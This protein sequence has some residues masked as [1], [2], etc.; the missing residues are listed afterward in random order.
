MSSIEN[1]TEKEDFETKVLKAQH[2]VLVDF[3]AQWCGPCR[4]LAPILDEV[5]EDV[6][7]KASVIKVNVDDNPEL[8]QKYGIR[9][10]PTMIFFKQ[11]KEANRLVG[12]RSKE[13]ITQN[14]TDLA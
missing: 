7:D 4:A 6:G 1:I 9:G 13:E 12:E 11:G 8:A 10:I 14:L 3:W 2:P 5:A